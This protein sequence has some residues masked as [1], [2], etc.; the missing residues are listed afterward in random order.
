MGNRSDRQSPVEGRYQVAL[1]VIDVQQGL[2]R[3]STKLYKAD[4]LLA[5]INDLVE[6]AHAA[7]AP[8]LYVLHSSEKVLSW[9]SEDWQLHPALHATEADCIIHK[10]KGNAFEETELDAE[11]ASRGVGAVVVTG[12]VTHGCVQRTC[13]GAHNL[14]YR[15][16]LVADGHSSYSKDAS[17]LIE[18]WNEKLGQ[19]IVQLQTARDVEF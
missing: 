9:G 4:E 6:R 16:V 1:L 13:I 7:R 12:L 11:L 8:V 17:K 14:G 18:E 3:K 10:L 15:V 5:T 19:G 2:F